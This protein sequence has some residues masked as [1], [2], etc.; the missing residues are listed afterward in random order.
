MTRL[1]RPLILL[2]VAAAAPLASL[3][4]AQA[5][6]V[7]K[8]VETKA[9]VTKAV[10]TDKVV[11]KKAEAAKVTVQPVLVP[12]GAARVVKVEPLIKQ[13]LPQL[14]PLMLA[15]LHFVRTA[16]DPTREQ[17]I[18]IAREGDRVLTEATRE[19][20]EAYQK[21]Q[22]GGWNG[23][24]TPPDP[25]RRIVEGIAGAVKAQLTPEQAARYRVEADKRAAVLKDVTVRNL[26]VNL[27]EELLLSADQ[28]LK[29]A[30]SLSSHWDAAWCRSLNQL[31]YGYGY[32]PNVPEPLI[33]PHLDEAQ[34][35]IWTA[36]PKVQFG[37]SWGNFNN[38]FFQGIAI[39]DPEDSPG[40]S[41]PATL[42][43]AGTG[44]A[45]K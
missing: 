23:T 24:S 26:V 18:A 4:L 14:R 22:Q 29:L 10:T 5:E 17:R 45:Q 36:R 21:M 19:Y 30:E 37:V 27:D 41:P 7:E 9:T 2:G 11:V 6:K 3:V 44:E 20:A 28:R 38:G 13:F 25:P 35:K 1:A 31:T 39:E 12:A 16:C 32:F 43:P 34:K 8:T 33:V 40:E 42:R 15:E